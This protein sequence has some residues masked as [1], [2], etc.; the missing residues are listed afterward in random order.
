LPRRPTTPARSGRAGSMVSRSPTS[1]NKPRHA[2]LYYGIEP[3]PRRDA[4]PNL[5]QREI[6]TGIGPVA[7]RRPRVRD[8]EAAEGERIRYSPSIVPPYARRSKNLEVLIPVLYLKGISRR[9][10]GS[11]GGPRRQGRARSIGLDHRPPQGG[12]DRGA[13]ALAEARSVSEEQAQCILVLIGA[14][15]EGRK[16][17]VGFTDGIRERAHNSG[18]ICCSI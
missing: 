11:A 4:V 18:V 6:M 16:E 7:V 8:R 10:R 5:P 15:P 17:L 3:D 14:T 12:V 1:G 9:L 2:G 13:Y